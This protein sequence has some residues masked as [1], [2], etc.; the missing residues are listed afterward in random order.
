MYALIDQ[1]QDYASD[2]DEIIDLE[3][4]KTPIEKYN[5]DDYDI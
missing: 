5:I 2:I 3:S 1:I 4:V